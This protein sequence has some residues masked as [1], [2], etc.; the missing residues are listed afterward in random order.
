MY[1]CN[2]YGNIEVV[3]SVWRTMMSAETCTGFYLEIIIL[4][5]IK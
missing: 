4:C 3:A 5:N 1:F 2:V